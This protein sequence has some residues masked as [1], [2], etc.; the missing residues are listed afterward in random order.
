M[1]DMEVEDD[2]FGKGIRRIEGVRR[3]GAL[4]AMLEEVLG[5]RSWH[6][7]VDEV[8]KAVERGEGPPGEIDVKQLARSFVHCD[9]LQ[10][11]AETV[12]VHNPL[13][14]RKLYQ[15]AHW[16]MKHTRIRG[17]ECSIFSPHVCVR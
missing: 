10:T 16:R 9:S 3:K 11:A 14:R 13:R 5:Q 17:G 15:V 12:K 4:S 7:V 8:Q 2:A 1:S 6:A